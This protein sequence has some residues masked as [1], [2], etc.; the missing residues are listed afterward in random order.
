M[1]SALREMCRAARSSRCWTHRRGRCA[2]GVTRHTHC[3]VGGRGRRADGGGDL[4]DRQPGEGRRGPGGAEP[5]PHA[6][7]RRDATG[8]RAC[9]GSIH[10]V[11]KG[12]L[13]AGMH[14]GIKPNRKDLALV[15]SD[16]ALRGRRPASR[17][18]RRRRRPVHRRGGA[19]C[20]RQACARCWSTAATPTRSPDPTG[21]DDVRAVCRPLAPALEACPRRPSDGLDRRHRRAAAG[22]ED[23]RRA[24]QAGAGAAGGS[25]RARRRGD[26]DH[27]H[28]H[29]ARRVADAAARRQDGHA[30][31]DLQG[32]RD[33]RA[34]SW[35]R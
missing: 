34:R 16:D 20:P 6:R 15:Y 23:R 22:A 26:H 24:A 11:A 10:E 21:L 4:G 1:R 8:S 29:E 14:A 12:F 28:P 9:E 17:S 5:Q 27:R 25:A 32:L 33:D 13:F 3:L 35:R 30:H 31:R 7:P 2:L 19:R 18:T